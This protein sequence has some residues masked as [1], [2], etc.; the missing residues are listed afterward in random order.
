MSVSSRESGAAGPKLEVTHSD[1][2]RSVLACLADA[3]INASTSAPIGYQTRLQLGTAVLRFE[4][5]TKAVAATQLVLNAYA[6]GGSTT[7][8][9]REFVSPMLPEPSP[10]YGLRARGLSGPT[11]IHATNFS[12]PNWWHPW[13][14]TL[15]ALPSSQ[16]AANQLVDVDLDTMVPLGRKAYLNEARPAGY[17]PRPGPLFPGSPAFD[18]TNNLGKELEEVY[19]QYRLRFGEGWRG[20]SMQSGKL[21]GIASDT[22]VAGNSGGQS[23][24]KNGWSFRGVFIGEPMSTTSPYNSNNGVVP[25]GWY[26]YNPDQII[27][28]QV[29]GLV[30]PWAGRGSLGLIEVGKDYWIDQYVK[31]NTPGKRDGIVRA[32]INGK[33]AYERTDHVM[34]GDPPYQVPGDLAIRKI[35]MTFLHGGP[36]DPQPTKT[37]RTYWSDWTIAK[38]YIGPPQG[39]TAK[40]PTISIVAP[41]NGALF[42]AGAGIVLSTSVLPGDASISKV[43]FY[44]DGALVGTDTSAP[45][46]I[47]LS[48]SIAGKHVIM[49]VVTDSANNV[50]FSS[51]ISISVGSITNTPP[52]LTISAPKSGASLPAKLGVACKVYSTDDR[53]V[54]KMMFYLNDRP[55][56]T[57]LGDKSPYSAAIGAMP[58]GKYT[59]KAVATDDQGLTSTATSTFT[60]TA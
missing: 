44:C 47:T 16:A 13:F 49:A 60:L 6:S 45:Y 51:P 28:K 19:F 20:G 56:A 2:S 11:L 46:G 7:I 14:T 32:W 58:V 23:N 38:E 21:P 36:L 25:I 29:Y 35:W 17:A 10:V 59:F 55:F 52:T 9:C 22:S 48:G 39:A 12:A 33:L 24:G 30:Y 37:L 27:E 34:R 1:G 50:S 42:T 43:D 41:A 8:E 26:T 4:R 15:S 5:P 53:A 57:F 3:A 40:P 18:F 54:G 31:V